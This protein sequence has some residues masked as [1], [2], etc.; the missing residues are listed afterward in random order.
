MS[1]FKT[2]TAQKHG[3]ALRAKFEEERIDWDIFLQAWLA[4]EK[5]R[6]ERGYAL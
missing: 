1:R 2:N 4:K 3:A 5:L 6:V